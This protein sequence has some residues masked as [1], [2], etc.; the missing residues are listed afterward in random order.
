MW[1]IRL[2]GRNDG[3]WWWTMSSTDRK[4]DSNSS[5]CRSRLMCKA[6]AF[7]NRLK[8]FFSNT[9]TSSGAFIRSDLCNTSLTCGFALVNALNGEVRGNVS[10]LW[11]AVR[12]MVGAKLKHLL[13]SP[14]LPVQEGGC[15]DCE[16]AWE[17]TKVSFDM[18]VCIQTKGRRNEQN[19]WMSPCLTLYGLWSYC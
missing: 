3:V 6:L 8:L 4:W 2:R 18:W 7:C 1:I 17:A 12:V 11:Q 10:S 14:T 19:L 15:V 5:S 9:L 16:T 13:A